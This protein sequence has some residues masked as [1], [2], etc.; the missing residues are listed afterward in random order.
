METG[1]FRLIAIGDR[2]STHN[3]LGNGLSDGVDLG[4]VAT[5]GDAD[6]DIDASYNFQSVP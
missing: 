2:S 6:A 1:Q 5:T 3:R 4:S